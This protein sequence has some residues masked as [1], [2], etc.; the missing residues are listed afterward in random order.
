MSIEILYLST[1]EY[2]LKTNGLLP[3]A[4]FIVEA[5]VEEQWVAV[6]EDYRDCLLVKTL[7][8]DWFSWDMSDRNGVPTT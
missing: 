3:Q 5:R 2:M 1:V 4:E 8:G 6:K 7:R